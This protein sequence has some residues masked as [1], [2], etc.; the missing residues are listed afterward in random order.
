MNTGNLTHQ[1]IKISF[2]SMAHQ[3]KT[4]INTHNTHSYKRVR[5]GVHEVTMRDA[6]MSAIKELRGIAKIGPGGSV[7][8]KIKRNIGSQCRFPLKTY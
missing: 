8:F 4:L 2:R 1:E 7:C 6:R 3:V 5:G